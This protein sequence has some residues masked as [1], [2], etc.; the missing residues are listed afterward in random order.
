MTVLPAPGGRPACPL[1]AQDPS[2]SWLDQV[3]LEIWVDV[4]RRPPSSPS[5]APST[6]ER[7]STSDQ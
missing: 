5:P 4:E 1:G 2:D 6:I 3:A 7:L